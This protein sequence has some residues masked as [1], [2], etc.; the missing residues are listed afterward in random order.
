M[1]ELEFDPLKLENQLCFPLYVCSKEVIRRYKPYLD[2]MD[3]TYT[4]YITLM[5]LWE[6]RKI[7]VR[8]LGECLYLDSG[9]M[10]PVLKKL[11]SKGYITRKRSRED[12]RSVFVEL[13]DKG[14][15]L[16]EKARSLPANMGRCVH[17]T[18]EEGAQLHQLLR[19]ILKG[20]EH[21]KEG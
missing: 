10:T 17:I 5:A 4:Q 20:L 3:L 9:T 16:K 11:E 1:D 7:S 2:P 18:P 19:K 6:H 14:L 12:E 21:K 15:A 8:E 13:T